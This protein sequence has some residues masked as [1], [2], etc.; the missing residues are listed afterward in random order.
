MLDTEENILSVSQ[1]N[2][3][4][5]ELLEEGLGVVQIMGE[6]SNW[7]QASSGHCYFSLKDENAQ[8]RC[9]CFRGQASRLKFRPENGLSVMVRAQVSLYPNRGDY[10]LIV[11]SM[12][13]AGQG[14]LALQF[15]KLKAKLQA[16]GLFDEDN[17]LPLPTLPKRIGIITSPTGAA[18]QDMKNVLARRFPLIPITLYPSLVQGDTAA[19]SLCAALQ[20]AQDDNR[21]DVLIL[22]RGGGS[23]EDLWAFND[24]TLAR[25]IVA[26][27]IPVISSVGHEVD[28][29]IADFA[30]D[31]RCP[32]PSAAAE[33]VVPDQ[34]EFEDLLQAQQLKLQRLIH[35]V[36]ERKTAQLK[37]LQAKL[38]HPKQLL[39]NQM[40]RLDYLHIQ[41]KER[42]QRFMT[43]YRN[44]LQVLSA[45]LDQ[46]SPLKLLQKGYTVL[47]QP[48]QKPL[49]SVTQAAVGDL[50]SAQLVDGDISLTVNKIDKKS[51]ETVE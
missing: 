51:L 41:L 42:L 10:Q 23:M 6:I 47:R 4:A 15:A 5:K 39:Q 3:L 43:H 34:R 32:T 7:V 12:Q 37:Q 29:T 38:L 45:T 48:N 50:V 25:M 44:R 20:Q 18:L 9:A 40:Q 14:Q 27:P 30:A 8:V 16:E 21:C 36:L 1:L 31:L 13:E 17:K 11:S 24:E 28:F 33:Q 19:G 26:C 49:T 22:A 2:H 46:Q 35:Y